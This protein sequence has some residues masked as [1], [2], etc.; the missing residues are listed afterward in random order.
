MGLVREMANRTF[1]S[2]EIAPVPSSSR[3]RFRRWV[4]IYGIS[5]LG[6]SLKTD[7]KVVHRWMH[8][9]KPGSISQK[10]IRSLIALSRIEPM[11]DGP[12]TYEDI[13][14]PVKIS[15][16]LTHS[17]GKVRNNQQWPVMTRRVI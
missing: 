15:R 2:V 13:I 12:L 9:N 17:F 8:P 7:R 14:G 11:D 16:E 6:R 3:D 4:R 1:L 5:R 10:K